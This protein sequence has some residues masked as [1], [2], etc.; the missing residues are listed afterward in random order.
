MVRGES[1]SPDNIED[2]V[3]SFGDL[4]D[5]SNIIANGN[6]KDYAYTVWGAWSG[7]TQTCG[8]RSYAFRKRYCINFVNHEVKRHCKKATVLAKRC[9]VSPCPG[10]WN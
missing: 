8:E 1:F 6:Q 7:C 9:V 3:D 2:Y 5:Y 10:L 4:K